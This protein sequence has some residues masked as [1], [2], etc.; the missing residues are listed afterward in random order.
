MDEN[1]VVRNGRT[2]NGFVVP[3]NRYLS[4]TYDAH[5]NVEMCHTITAIKYLFKYFY[6]GH[7]RA[8][9][10]VSK[11]D[12]GESIDEIKEYVDARCITP[13]EAIWRLMENPLHD[14]SHTITKLA[15]HLENE[16]QVLFTERNLQQN[17]NK[18]TS[19]DTTLTAWFKLNKND[20]AA[21]EILYPDIPTKYTFTKEHT[22][23]KRASVTTGETVISRIYNVSPRH[24]ELYHLR[25]LLLNVPGATEFKD[26]KTYN[27]VTY[28]TFRE[29][30]L[31]RGLIV[32][33]G[34]WKRC[35]E[36]ASA[37][38][39]PYE[40]RALFAILLIHC[41]VINP[42]ELWEQFQRY[43]IED[44]LKHGYDETTAITFALQHIKRDLEAAGLSMRDKGLPE[45][46]LLP[47][48]AMPVEDPTAFINAG[49]DMMA[50]L[51]QDQRE[52][53]DTIMAAISENDTTK[54]NCIFID[55]PGGTGET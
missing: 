35:M 40:L 5:I 30:A 27:S 11:E 8:R 20:P 12:Q 39:M 38:M 48:E 32:D 34:E 49:E 1:H 14:Q 41:E 18:A 9:I 50:N 31:A 25:L 37:Y 53:T 7:D 16:Q 29:A 21:R 23:K 6:K 47:E 17:V 54:A 42:I 55:G 22:W 36:E 26:L 24:I 2:H 45:P 46:G 10:A 33:D 51:N 15:V 4:L 3:Y 44:Y 52:I 28:N 43:M 13:P 19:K